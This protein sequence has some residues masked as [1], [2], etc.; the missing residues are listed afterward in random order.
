MV[1]VQLP[2]HRLGIWVLSRSGWTKW[3]RLAEA[4]DGRR[5]KGC[6]LPLP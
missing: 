2:P 5:A 3:L 1:R 4:S 6:A